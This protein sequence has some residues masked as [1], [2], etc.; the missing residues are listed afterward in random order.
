MMTRGAAGCDSASCH[1]PMPLESGGSS[2]NR[3]RRR[4]G[5]PFPLPALPRDDKTLLGLSEPRRANWVISS[6]NQL[7]AHPEFRHSQHS[8][9]QA[10]PTAVQTVALDHILQCLAEAGPPPLGLSPEKA[11]GELM[12]SK[13][14]YNG[15]PN[16]LA[17]YDPEKLKVLKSK[18]RPQPLQR[19]LPPHVKPLY[20]RFQSHIERTQPDIQQRLLDFPDRCPAQPYWDPTLRQ[21]KSARRSLIKLLYHAGVIGFR[22]KI[23]AKVGFFSVKKKDP[24]AIRLVIDAR[25]P[26]FCHHSP[27][28]TRLG[29]AY[30]FC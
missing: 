15:V 29:S 1:A 23:K 28:V 21:D 24:Q 26:N 12:A 27:P 18:F 16:N 11:F 10:P 30:N 22:T 2:F 9:Q 17:A 25:I 8:R 6:L 13:S 14:L 20:A 3:C 5:D 19:I 7:V 4:H